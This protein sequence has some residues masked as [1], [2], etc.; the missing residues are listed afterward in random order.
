MESLSKYDQLE[1]QIIEVLKSLLESLNGKIS[2]QDWDSDAYWTKSIKEKLYLIAK[3]P[4]NNFLVAT[5]GIDKKDWGEW[6][7][8]M[9][10]YKYEDNALKDVFLVVESEWNIEEENIQDDFEKLLVAKSR[11]RLMIFQADTEQ[12]INRII[13]SFNKIIDNFS[14]SNKGDRFLYAAYNI[15]KEQFFFELKIK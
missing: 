11:H 6:L 14:L 1:K 15:Q 10:W 4:E 5:S 9:V 13:E 3:M 8:D 2:N 12:T 7:F